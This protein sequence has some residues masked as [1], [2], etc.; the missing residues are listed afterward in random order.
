[1]KTYKSDKLWFISQSRQTL[2]EL[3]AANYRV[4]LIIIIVV[5]QKASFEFFFICLTSFQ[6]T[7]DGM[8]KVFIV[9]P[10]LSFT[11]SVKLT[12]LFFISPI[13]IAALITLN[14]F[15]TYAIDLINILYIT[16]R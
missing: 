15:I 3:R 7:L 12:V 4:E 9:L 6:T 5:T 10:A 14:D 1:M 16:Y 2:R 13:K 11:S 8:L